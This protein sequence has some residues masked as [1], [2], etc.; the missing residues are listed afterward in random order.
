MR[1]TMKLVCLLLTVLM[2]LALVACKKPVTPV[3]P[4]E[5]PVTTE[6]PVEQ[7]TEEPAGPTIEIPKGPTFESHT[8]AGTRAVVADNTFGQKFSPFFYTTAY[9]G[10]IVGMVVTGLLAAD[11]GGAVLHN[12][13]QG[14]TVPYNG[15][16]YTYYGMANI[17]IVQNDDGSV[18]YNIVMRDDLKFS[19]GHPI[20]IDD[21]I[22]GIYVTADPTYDGSSTLYALP[23]EGVKDYYQSMAS[24]ISL[25][26]AN[27]GA[28]YEQNEIFNEEDYNN[29]YTAFNEAGKKFAQSI[30]DYVCE[31]YL[32]DAY[33]KAY[34]DENL[35]AED[36]AADEK[37]QN[38]YGCVIWGFDA[39]DTPE[40]YWNQIINA[41]EWDISSEGVEKEA[42]EYSF[43]ELLAAELG[44]K[45]DY[46]NEF[47]VTAEGV[48]NI[49]GIIR[50][51]D[52]SMTVHCTEFDAT[53]IY[54]MS[55]W[56]APLHYY[57][58][59]SLYDYENNSFGFV[60]G[61][62]S[63]VRS[64]TD[65]PMGAGPYTYEGY[66][67]GVV[68]LKANPNYYLGA[69][70][71]E[72][73]LFQEAKDSDYVPG[74]VSGTFDI[75]TPSINENTLNAIKD[76]NSNGELTGDTITTYLVDYRGY[77]YI[78]INAN[79]VCMNNDAGSEES[80]ALRKGFM[81]LLSVY[82]ETVINSYYGD[83]A[84]VIQYPI[85]NTSWAAPMPADPGYKNAYS[86]DVDGNPIYTEGMNDEQKYAAAREAAIGY[87]KAAGL[88]FDEAAGKF[89]DEVSYEIMI[90]GN[91][92]QDHPAYGIA[93][94]ASNVLEE[95]GIKLQ[96][97]DV[98]GATWN[99]ALEANTADMWAAAW[100]AGVD[101]DMY[102]VY[103]STN[104]N[105][106]GTNSNHYQIQDTELDKLII[107]GRTSADNDFRK[108][109]YKEAMEIIL[110]W[111]VE[112]P[113][114]Q[115]KEC[116]TVS[117]QRINNDTFT[118]DMTPFWGW[119]GNWETTEAK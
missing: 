50:T 20:D 89:T 57:G 32:I 41:Y 106:Q 115:R 2:V 28:G 118:P 75:N 60:K 59:E 70:A 3:E 33:V 117:T 85:S 51:G 83:R 37:L 18:D 27:Q 88:T 101:P 74:I 7:P 42:A 29:F 34:L 87:F 48:N 44:D 47:V 69:P 112:L 93:V 38:Q 111:G 110:D 61:D 54:N 90:P 81:T 94:A 105:G 96:V 86:T 67:N 108:A 103:H 24:R 79:R 98:T 11:R 68:T 97:N 9:D 1:K 10:D 78:G 95:L 17:D 99:N 82:R 40:E 119:T 21:V 45:Y 109:T 114:Y 23:I 22:F 66:E 13:V 84:V 72:T 73:L 25:I 102:Q 104:A 53:A 55:F 43:A 14:E 77:G 5:A 8:V 31:N 56:V 46:Y 49:P 58:D 116:T 65:K 100:Q 19:D 91:G 62:L 36:V 113:T 30:V 35:T 71:I 107:E 64:H 76:G 39:C 26:L 80:K 15:K 12:G 63:G 92:E 4:T 52:Y 16:D 6:A